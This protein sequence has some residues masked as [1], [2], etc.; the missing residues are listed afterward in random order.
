MLDGDGAQRLIGKTED[1]VDHLKLMTMRIDRADLLD[2]VCNVIDVEV[3]DVEKWLGSHGLVFLGGG[4]G[5]NDT[6]SPNV[7]QLVVSVIEALKGVVPLGHGI[8][9]IGFRCVK[10]LLGASRP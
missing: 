3:G 4:A 8:P 7:R 9:V 6:K 10:S 1:G 5:S 2:V